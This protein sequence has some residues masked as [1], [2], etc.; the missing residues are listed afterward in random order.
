MPQGGAPADAIGVAGDLVDLGAHRLPKRFLT[1]V[2]LAPGIE[3]GAVV[4]LGD[5]VDAKR[6]DGLAELQETP[7]VPLGR[8]ARASIPSATEQD[9]QT[10]ALGTGGNAD[11]KGP[12]SGAP[13]T[14]LPKRGPAVGG[15]EAAIRMDDSASA[16]RAALIGQPFRA[17]RAVLFEP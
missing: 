3:I 14:R 15:S 10:F 16:R 6:P 9:Q 8:S 1:P 4:E 17:R 5:L 7:G 2:V 11:R 13:G 12:G